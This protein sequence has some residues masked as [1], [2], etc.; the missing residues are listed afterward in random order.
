MRTLLTPSVDDT[1]FD[2][3]IDFLGPCL[4]SDEVCCSFSSSSFPFT[5]WSGGS[6]LRVLGL[7]DF[8]ASPPRSSV[9]CFTDRIRNLGNELLQRRW[10]REYSAEK[11]GKRVQCREE[12]REYGAE[13]KGKRVQCR[14]SNISTSTLLKYISGTAN[15]KNYRALPNPSSLY[16][17]KL[18][19]A[20][21]YPFPDAGLALLACIRC[22]KLDSVTERWTLPRLISSS[23][24]VLEVEKASL[25]T[26]QC[27]LKKKA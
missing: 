26:S 22:D 27:I 1:I 21:P 7:E 17:W 20:S 23:R 4:V 8:A 5:D 12:G 18:L 19:S 11:K 25:R 16:L 9:G 6:D 3:R 14:E 15:S 13:K 10:E 2:I 24:C